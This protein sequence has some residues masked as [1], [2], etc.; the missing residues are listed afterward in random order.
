MTLS[1]VTFDSLFQ[2]IIALLNDLVSVLV[3]WGEKLRRQHGHG[4]A[5]VNGCKCIFLSSF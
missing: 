4:H 1:E 5:H 3:Y 2:Y